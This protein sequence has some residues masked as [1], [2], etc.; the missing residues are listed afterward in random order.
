M[1]TLNVVLLLTVISLAKVQVVT[2]IAPLKTFIEKIGGKHVSVSTLLPSNANPHNF[3]LAPSQM[4][5]VNKAELLVK[6]GTN[7]EF[8][9]VILPKLMQIN[10]QTL[11]CDASI[12]VQKIHMAEHSHEETNL[13]QNNIDPHIWLSPH[14]AVLMTKT[15]KDCL[16]AIDA[17]NKEH[18]EVKAKQFILELTELQKQ[19]LIIIKNGKTKQFLIYHPAWGYFC[20]EFG[21]EQIPIEIGAK[22]PTAKKL[23][24]IVKKA[25]EYNIKTVF[26]EPQFN[27]KSAEVIAKEING[28]VVEID[29][30]SENYVNNLLEVAKV[31]VE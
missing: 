18:Y 9:H 2:T 11:V 23:V 13:T 5:I 10:K 29:P 17:K 21:L 25:R 15:I 7:I 4:R 27:K 19:I 26:I 16:V 3:E 6:V 30:L 14:N 28:K 1:K 8:E 31:I 22:E 12:G 24:N 20:R